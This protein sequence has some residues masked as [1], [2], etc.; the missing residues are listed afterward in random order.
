VS[1]FAGVA[2][3]S[4][5]FDGSGA[6]A[7]FYHPEG[8]A[9]DAGG[10]VYVADTWNH[11]VR[12]ISPVGAVTTLAGLA[13]NFGAA[14]G[15]NSK[16]RF[17]RP[18][19]IAVDSSTNVFV[20]DSLNHT[21]RKIS[22]SGSVSTIAG[23]AGVWGSSDGTN[24]AAHFYMPEGIGIAA[25]GDLF[26]TDSGNQIIRKVS[27]VG[28]N[29]VVTTVAGFSGF[30]GSANGAG[31][32]AQFDFPAAIAF[33]TAGYLYVADTGNNSIR[34]T[35]IISPS[36]Q[37]TAIANQSILSWPTWADGFVL[38][39]SQTLGTTANWASVTNNIAIADNFVHTND[40][41]ESA[42]FRLH[43]Q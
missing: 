22:P 25:N 16:A 14:D 41:A 1:T 11:T 13:G 42:Y 4:N 30:A 9:T 37:I 35:R 38:E 27:L 24:S 43:L 23:L 20:A 2:G 7:E 28:T 31:S 19:G 12:K 17:N 26:V 33:D 39:Q 21:I 8:V 10:S 18:T 34:S 6:N 5:S 36:L 32:N 3:V 29:W 40:L 15:T